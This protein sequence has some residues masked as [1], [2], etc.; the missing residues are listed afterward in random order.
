MAYRIEVG[1]KAARRLSRL[2][3]KHRQQVLRR[4][5]DLGLDPR[6]P[7]A[8]K[9]QVLNGYRV[10]CGEYRILYTVDDDAMLVRVY[11]IIQRG[12]GYPD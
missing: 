11:L 4:I 9:L 12:E 1:D 5:T 10:R 8:A 2:P 7:Q 3:A 6:P